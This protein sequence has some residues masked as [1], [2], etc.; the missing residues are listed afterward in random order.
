MY[1][2]LLIISVFMLL[3]L[4]GYTGTI[5]YANYSAGSTQVEIKSWQKSRVFPDQEGWQ[6]SYDDLQ[7]TLELD[8]GNPEYLDIE[9]MLFRVKALSSKP[10]S[11]Q[12]HAANREALKRYRRLTSL[13]P[14]WAPYWGIIVSIKYDLWEFDESM[15]TALHNAARLAPW[16]KSNQHTI[17]RAGFHGW[18]FIDNE[19]REVVNKT[20][21]RA[22]QLQPHPTIA[23]AAKQGYLERVLPYVEGDEELRG[24][25]ERAVA[26]RKKRGR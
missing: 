14:S 8:Q 1:R 23:M 17:L 26:A 22:M 3:G 16:F 4:A 13:R 6:K 10:G 21:E 5:L 7:N 15:I 19:T 12:S 9:A 18:P 20:L 25:Y 11:E 2:L 24:V